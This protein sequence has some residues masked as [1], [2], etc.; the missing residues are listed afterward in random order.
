M[1]EVLTVNE[2]IKEL[3]D[4]LTVG[5]DRWLAT[6]E[7]FWWILDEVIPPDGLPNPEKVNLAMALRLAQAVRESRKEGVK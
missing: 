3:G 6:T 5:G 4:R 1:A 7:A 2:A